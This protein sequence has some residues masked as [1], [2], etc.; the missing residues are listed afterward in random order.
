MLTSK[1]VKV[2]KIKL[3]FNRAFAQKKSF[4][5]AFTI[6]LVPIWGSHLPADTKVSFN[7]SLYSSMDGP[8][9]TCPALFAPSLCVF[10]NSSTADWN[11]Q[12]KHLWW[13]RS[14]RYKF[15]FECTSSALKYLLSIYEQCMYKTS[16]WKLFIL[17]FQVLYT[18]TQQHLWIC[19]WQV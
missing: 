13:I 1:Q 2:N 11:N 9:G 17:R 12:G 16:T 8:S 15:F 18:C 4:E 5:N 19:Y 14:I 3:Y 10:I 6:R 7:M